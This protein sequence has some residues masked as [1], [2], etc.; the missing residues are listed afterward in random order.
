M[1]KTSLRV[2]LKTR[3]AT[4][5]PD[6]DTPVPSRTLKP[7]NPEFR[8]VPLFRQIYL[9]LSPIISWLVISQIGIV[10]IISGAPQGEIARA[11]DCFA[12]E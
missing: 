5:L 4:F 10:V 6:P 12:T 7:S 9:S 8:N 1:L 3:Y 2:H 11:D